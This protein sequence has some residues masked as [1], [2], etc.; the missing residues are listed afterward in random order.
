MAAVPWSNRG[1]KK[2]FSAEG[3]PLCAAGCYA[4]AAPF[5]TA[6]TPWWPTSVHVTPV[7]CSSSSNRRKLPSRP[8]EL[9]QG[10]V[11]HH[12]PTSPGSRIRHELDREARMQRTLYKQRT[13][14]ER[15]NSQALELGIE[16]PKLRN[17]RSISNHN[18][19]LYVLIDLQ[20]LQR[21]QAKTAM[22]AQ[23]AA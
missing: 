7:H 10:R 12:P 14:T 6:A 21:V 15:I 13:A 3:L 1:E 22:A 4:A 2:S 19:L 17:R 23:A 9:A 20:A 18:T 5:R 16:R 8:C 11:P